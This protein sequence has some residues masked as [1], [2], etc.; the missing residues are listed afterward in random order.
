MGIRIT[1]SARSL[2]T[3]RRQLPNEKHGE[4]WFFETEDRMLKDIASHQY[5]EYGKH[6]GHLYGTKLSSVQ[7]LIKNDRIPVLD[8]E[9]PVSIDRSTV[10]INYRESGLLSL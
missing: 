4:L 1:V 10:K 5:L 2:D 7:D 9:T 8:I 6:D 3:S